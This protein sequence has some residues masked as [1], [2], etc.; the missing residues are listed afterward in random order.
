MNT[1]VNPQSRDREGLLKNSQPCNPKRE[2]GSESTGIQESNS[3]AD[4]S[5]YIFQLGGQSLGCCLALPPISGEVGDKRT[6]LDNQSG[7]LVI[8]RFFECQT[9]GV[10]NRTRI[11]S[12][13]WIRRQPDSNGALHD[14]DRLSDLAVGQ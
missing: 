4:A 7:N 5:G 8:R 11:G 13:W 9:T 2:R 3:L 14:H 10:G 12:G 6:N 1:S